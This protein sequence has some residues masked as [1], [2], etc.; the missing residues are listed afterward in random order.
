LPSVLYGLAKTATELGNKAILGQARLPCPGGRCDIGRHV[1]QI[2]VDIGATAEE[3]AEWQPWLRRLI[4]EVVPATVRVRLRW[5]SAAIFERD[6]RLGDT[7]A[8]GDAPEPHLGTD[9]V[10]GIARL[11]DRGGI[12]LSDPGVDGDSPLH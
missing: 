12:S 2:R 11:P 6:V 9:A 7:L 4:E 1:G 8:L 5:L 3:R 10:T